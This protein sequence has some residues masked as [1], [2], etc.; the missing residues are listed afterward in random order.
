MTIEWYGSDRF[1]K[2]I[3]FSNVD[4]TVVPSVWYENLP[5]VVY[6]SLSYGIPVIAS[7]IGGIPEMVEDGKNGLL[8]EPGNADELLQK[9]VQVSDNILWWKNKYPEIKKTSE[10]FFDYERWISEWNELISKVS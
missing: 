10:P 9:L 5:G 6:E 1:N 7:N 2:D 4:F 8:F 3:F